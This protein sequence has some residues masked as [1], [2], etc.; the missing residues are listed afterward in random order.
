MYPL[1]YQYH[2]DQH[3]SNQP[4]HDPF[5]LMHQYYVPH[6]NKDKHYISSLKR[7]LREDEE[8]F[9]PYC[10]NTHT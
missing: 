7:L 2:V 9:L 3:Q 4:H 1:K 8:Y 10:V 6:P 5:D